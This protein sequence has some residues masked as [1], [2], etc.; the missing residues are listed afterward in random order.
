MSGTDT[1]RRSPTDVAIN[2]ALLLVFVFGYLLAEDWSL[3]AA[4]FPQ[5]FTGVGVGLTLLRLLLLLRARRR[6]AAGPDV[7][8]VDNQA[9]EESEDI[10]YVFS[11][12][13]GRTWLQ[14]LAWI[15]VFFVGLYLVGLFVIVPV[16]SFAYLRAVART[17]W[18][19][20]AIYAVTMWAV[21]YLAFGVLLRLRM[22]AGIL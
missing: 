18:W 19:A 14:A 13:D 10:E 4:L 8:L 1:T 21:L 5:I 2:V 16:F 17:R 6:G 22:P 20:A 9:E 15:A 7:T 11:H 3:R 12:A